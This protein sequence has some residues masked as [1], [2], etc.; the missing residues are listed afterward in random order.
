L[1]QGLITLKK[2][3]ILLII[4]LTFLFFHFNTFLFCSFGQSN[5]P[6]SGEVIGDPRIAADYI[7]NGNYKDALKEYLVLLKEEPENFDFKINIAICYL[8]TNIDKSKAIPYLE[9]LISQKNILP[10]IYFHLGRA[11]HLN[12]KFDEAIETFEKFKAL[13]PKETDYIKQADRLIEM[14]YNGK[15]LIK[16]PLDVNF[17]NVGKEVN[18]EY[19][20]YAPFVPE[21]ESFM[22]FSTR[23]KGGTGAIIDVDGFATSDVFISQEKGGKW[24]KS[25][26]IGYAVNTEYDEQV[27][28]LTPDGRNLLVF[29]NNGDDI[30]GDLYISSVA[31]GKNFPKA[32]PLKGVNTSKFE[33][34]ASLNAE[35]DELY[36]A[37]EATNSIGGVDLYVSKKLPNGDWGTPVNLGPNVNT[38]FDE[39]YP[40]VSSNGKTLYFCSQGRT[41]MGG[42]DIFKADFDDETQSWQTPVN[43]GYP[44]NTP[45]DD[46]TFSMAKNKKYAY[47][48]A[49]RPGGFGDVDIY[50]VNFEDVDDPKTALRGVV[51]NGDSANPKISAYIT[52]TNIETSEIV[53]NYVPIE[54]NGKYIIILPSG[55]FNI[56]I[57]SEGYQPYSEDIEILDKG[58]FKAEIIKDFIMLN[59][60]VPQA[61]EKSVSPK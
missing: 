29:I 41:A 61:S 53:G 21:D 35:R 27:V 48:S 60:G 43:I 1:N 34:A 9:Y 16:F 12:Y 10:I 55:K 13:A 54:K 50:Q 57:E 56:N 17:K 49:H 31:K 59:E 42:F 47:V 38:E 46:L 2:S 24:A 39:N 33:W 58:S 23:R 52:V 30:M 40:L 8:N 26:S 32:T 51:F 25:K 3:G 7:K 4:R 22:V 11:Y 20:D 14:C 28:G 6:T 19:P 5:T 36:F 37:A 45:N 44:I 18:S 15:E